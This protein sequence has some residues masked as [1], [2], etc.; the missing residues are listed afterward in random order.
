VRG[1]TRRSGVLRLHLVVP[2]V[3]VGGMTPGMLAGV[4]LAGV[5]SEA[6]V[7]E[8]AP[9]HRGTEMV[10]ALALRDGVEV[11]IPV[12]SGQGGGFMAMMGK[13]EI[14][15]GNDQGKLRLLVPNIP[16]VVP[17]V[18]RALAS[19]TATGPTNT[20]A[21]VAYWLRLTPGTTLALPLGSVGK[22]GLE[23]PR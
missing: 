7:L 5:L 2:S 19:W 20:M 21:G 14:I 23:V 9:R 12:S 11:A 13:L 3:T 10:Y 1:V 15:L 18:T 6:G 16:F 17:M 8:G 4:D 22:L